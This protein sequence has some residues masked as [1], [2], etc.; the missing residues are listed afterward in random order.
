VQLSGRIQNAGEAT[1]TQV[2]VV[3]T[4]YD[5]Q[6]NVTGYYQHRLQGSLAANET[7][8]FEFEVT[9]PGGQA[10]DYSLSVQ[11]VRGEAES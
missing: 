9:P 5:S 6:G 3:A 2:T 8:S 4:L 10:V 1:A 11:A 7:D